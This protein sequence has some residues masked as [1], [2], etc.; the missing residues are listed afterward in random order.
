[1]EIVKRDNLHFNFKKI[2]SYNKTFNFAI[3]EREPGKSTALWC[4]K[5]YS[6]YKQG[7]TSII[8]RRNVVDINDIY[9]ND[10]IEIIRKFIDPDLKIFYKA[11]SLKDGIVDIYVIENIDGEEYKKHLC[12]L[13]GLSMKLS[14]LK[15][16]MLRNL[17]Y[18]IFDEFIC[19]TKIG[20]SYLKDEAF[21][22][23]EMVNTFQRESSDLK[24]FFAGNPYSLFNPYFIYLEVDSSKLKRGVI[25]V[26]SNWIVQCYEMKEELRELIKKRNPLY[27]FDNSYTKYAFDGLN[28]NDSNIRIGKM[29]KNY[30]MQHLFQVGDKVLAVYRNRD[31]NDEDKYFVELTKEYSKYRDIYVFDINDLCNGTMLFSRDER[32]KFMQLKNAFRFRKI[33]FKNI[34]CYYLFEEVFQNL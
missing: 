31:L 27:Q 11:S 26:G 19:N 10:S 4:D 33:V 6:A 15:S 30:F 18:I 12:R 1:M 3:S 21:K 23:M 13:I 2:D 24:I 17:K 8:V 22:F 34:E 25:Q 32:F 16:L 5:V 7:R 28:I 14:R 20:E 9:I 29:E